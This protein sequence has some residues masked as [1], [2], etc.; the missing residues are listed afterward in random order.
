MKTLQKAQEETKG[1]ERINF[2]AHGCNL[3]LE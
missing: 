3:G 2:G 1:Y